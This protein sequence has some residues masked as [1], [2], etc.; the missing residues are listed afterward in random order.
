MGQTSL[1]MFF[2]YGSAAF[3]FPL[4]E[5]FSEIPIFLRGVIYTFCIFF[6][7]FAAGSALKLAGVCPWDYSNAKYN[8]RGVIRAD[9]APLWFGAGLFFEYVYRHFL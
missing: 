2:I 4:F 8:L 5:F 6:V 9:F 1:W 7:E 3:F